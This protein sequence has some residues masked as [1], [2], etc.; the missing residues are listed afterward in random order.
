MS[1]LKWFT[2]KNLFVIP[3]YNNQDEV[4]TRC[5]MHLATVLYKEPFILGF[6]KGFSTFVSIFSLLRVLCPWFF[7][8]R[9]ALSSDNVLDMQNTPRRWFLAE[10]EGYEAKV[11]TKKVVNISIYFWH[12]Q[13]PI[14]PLL[15]RVFLRL[16]QYFHFYVSHG[17]NIF[18]HKLS[19]VCRLFW[20]C[21]AYLSDDFR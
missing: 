6:L 5:S 4:L 11:F 9:I 18:S 3:S 14:D 12:P 13:N 2:E 7:Y 20:I 15:S 8:W 10:L 21:K 17:P 1:V 16:L 19:W